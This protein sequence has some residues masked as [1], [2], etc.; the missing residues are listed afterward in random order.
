MLPI[1]VIEDPETNSK[2]FVNAKNISQNTYFNV[3][4]INSL[5]QHLDFEK[6]HYTNAEYISFL[7][8]VRSSFFNTAKNIKGRSMVRY[9]RDIIR[10]PTYD[11]YCL[12]ERYLRNNKLQYNKQ[13]DELIQIK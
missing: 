13:K 7:E 12:L 9:L 11:E 3:L 1:K 10:K 2:W 4:S 8:V 5:K 6:N